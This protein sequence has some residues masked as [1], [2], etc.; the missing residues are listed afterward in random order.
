[1]KMKKALLFAMSLCISTLAVA[2]NTSVPTP[3]EKSENRAMI[4]VKP[5]PRN[6]QIAKESELMG[7][8]QQEAAITITEIPSNSI[9]LVKGKPVDKQFRDFAK[10]AG[11][12]LLWDAPEYVLD[13]NEFI[14]GNFVEALSAFLKNTNESGSR[15]RPTFYHGNMTVR[16]QEF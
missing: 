14:K 7:S 16:V 11:W 1:M 3:Q 10:L 15:L 9:E 4:A 12:T 5:L 13:N 6:Q 8:V 2:V